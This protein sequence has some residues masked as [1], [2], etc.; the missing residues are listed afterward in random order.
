MTFMRYLKGLALAAAFAVV[1][2]LGFATGVQANSHDPGV[3]I[4]CEAYSNAESCR[5]CL[6]KPD[7]TKATVPAQCKATV[8]PCKVRLDT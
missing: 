6:D 4:R 2:G 7:S 1:V 8:A 5:R 3:C